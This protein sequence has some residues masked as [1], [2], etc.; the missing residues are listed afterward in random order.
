MNGGGSYL[1]P[2]AFA[3]LAGADH[4]G[5]PATAKLHGFLHGQVVG[6]CQLFVVH[7][8]GDAPDSFCIAVAGDLR[9]AGIHV[10]DDA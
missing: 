6:V 2:E 10:F 3:I 8:L 9:V 4:E 7:Q 1:L 5:F